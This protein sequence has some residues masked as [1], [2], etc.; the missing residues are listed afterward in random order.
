M[1]YQIERPNLTPY[2]E[3]NFEG[4]NRVSDV[5]DLMGNTNFVLGVQTESGANYAM[6]PTGFTDYDR[7]GL[8][9]VW[10]QRDGAMP[11]EQLAG[12]GMWIILSDIA[13]GNHMVISST[14]RNYA[15]TT[16]PVVGLLTR[17]VS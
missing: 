17:Q 14:E 13:L 5:S 12:C 8:P 15:P 10:L 16:T 3:N 1:K 2:L 4:F 9:I 11:R 7:P 6:R